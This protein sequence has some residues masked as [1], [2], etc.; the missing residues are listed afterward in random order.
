VTKASR[1]VSIGRAAAALTLAIV[2]AG[3]PAG[4]ANAIGFTK[5]SELCASPDIAVTLGG[6]TVTP[7]EVACST[8]NSSGN[9]TSTINVVSFEDPMGNP[10]IPAGVRVTGY[11]PNGP[12]AL[13]TIDRAAALSTGPNGASVLVSPRDVVQFVTAGGTPLTG[14]QGGYFS[15][16]LF[17]QG[18]ANGIFPGVRIDALSITE[19]PVLSFDIAVS[20]SAGVIIDP[21]DV[22]ELT[23][24]DAYAPLFE[25]LSDVGGTNVEG[26]FVLP[27]NNL[28]LSFDTPGLLPGPTGTVSFQPY[29]VVE[30]NGTNWALAY[31]GTVDGWLPGSIIQ[32][33]YAIPASAP[34]PTAT[35]TPA[36]TAP[37][38]PTAAPTPVPTPTPTVLPTAN[39]TSTPTSLP[40][41]TPPAT[42]VLTPTPTV[43]LTP[44]PTATPSATPSPLTGGGSVKVISP[45]PGSPLSFKTIGTGSSA[46]S[47][48]TI[49]NQGISPLNFELDLSGLPNPPFT[50]DNG[51]KPVS[52]ANVFTV[53]ENARKTLTVVFTPGTLAQPFNGV[54]GIHSSDSVNP[55]YPIDVTAAAV[56]GTLFV[57]PKNLEVNF[58]DVRLGQRKT[59]SLTLMNTHIGLLNVNVPDNLTL[60]FSV[61]SGSGIFTLKSGKSRTVVVQFQPPTTVQTPFTFT[62][63]LTI[64]S[65]DPSALTVPITVTGVATSIGGG[66]GD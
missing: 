51:T 28:L 3:F 54:I 14:S 11:Y 27:N 52:G 5:L 32:G 60:P 8:F 18:S 35:P 25:G 36:P 23:G 57:T 63:T 4:T 64:T 65:D 38:T 45:P 37:P 7:Q 19:V 6:Q 44:M 9:P 21:A 29:Q 46:S 30:F 34:T 55:Y 12:G 31:D 61:K 26:A 2:L 22:V 42:P 66:A 53:K 24:V 59:K 49:G 50:V 10:L 1:R 15:S 40:T 17:F 20:P 41:A 56:S 43:A 48:L 39:P 58:K 62:Q 16:S 47:K 33:V 13:I